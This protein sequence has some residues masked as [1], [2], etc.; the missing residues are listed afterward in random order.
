MKIEESHVLEYI[1][2][3]LIK[4][5]YCQEEKKSTN[6]YFL[7]MKLEHISIFPKSIDPFARISPPFPYPKG[8]RKTQ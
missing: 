1:R 2:H 4:G 8:S 3:G 5:H 6:K 7:P